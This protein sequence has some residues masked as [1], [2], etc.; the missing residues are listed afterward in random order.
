MRMWQRSG[1]FS[2]TA[3]PI[4]SSIRRRRR[5]L[6]GGSY[7]SW[8]G[9]RIPDASVSWL[10]ARRQFEARDPRAPVECTGVLKILGGVPESAV[11]HRVDRDA[12]VIA[13]AV[14]VRKL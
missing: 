2:R 10:L 7:D 14:K 3:S 1:Q 12:A 13:P 6:S 4:H 9:V 11:V 5:S 8:K